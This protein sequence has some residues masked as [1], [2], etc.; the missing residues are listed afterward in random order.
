MI[1]TRTFLN[2]RRREARKVITSP[3]AMHAALLSGFPP[4]VDPGRV[5]W[6]M[7]GDNNAQATVWMVSA[8]TPDLTHLEEQAG[9]PSRST[10]RSV[11]YD[12][13]L[14]AL[15]KGQTW[16][17]RLTANP[18]HRG[19]RNGRTQVFAHVTADQQTRW[20]MHRQGR[21]GVSLQS[22]DGQPMFAME[23]RDIKQF[24]RS[25]SLVT[26]GVATFG[27]ILKVV[28]PALLRVALTAGIGRGKAYGCGLLTLARP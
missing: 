12:G 3:Q 6:R 8:E 2:P 19:K 13:L 5:L 22:P 20:L 4:N 28:D 26:L 1:L 9:W 17:F 23:G 15:D 14:D 21:L 25:D 10:T 24:R 27:G 16:A 11:G 18:T 7:D